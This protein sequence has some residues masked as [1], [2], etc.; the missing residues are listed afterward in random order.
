S[1]RTLR[2]FRGDE[3]LQTVEPGEERRVRLPEG[4]IKVVDDHDLVGWV[5]VTPYPTRVSGGNC[6]FMFP[7]L[8]P[9]RYRLRGWHPRGGERSQIVDVTAGRPAF[10]LF[11]FGKGRIV[12]TA[13]RAWKQRE[14]APGEP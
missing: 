4:I 11:P 7:E 6:R 1:E 3:L 5:Y 8:P 13:T 2:F 14:D 9:G 12:K 10:R